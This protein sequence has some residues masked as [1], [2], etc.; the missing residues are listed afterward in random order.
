ML[1]WNWE[2][3]LELTCS[4]GFWNKFESSNIDF[5][6]R[7]SN[8]DKQMASFLCGANY[9]KIGFDSLWW[10]NSEENTMELFCK[11]LR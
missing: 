8:K 11:L 9:V 4:N 7:W 10:L 1:F 6:Y 5:Y 2:L 3:E